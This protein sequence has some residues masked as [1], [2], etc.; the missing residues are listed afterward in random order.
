MSHKSVLQ[1][2]HLDIC[3][4]S[5]VLAFGFV[6]SILFHFSFGRVWIIC[7]FIPFFT[8]VST[9]K[10]EFRL[11]KSRKCTLFWR[12]R[13]LQVYFLC[14]CGHVR[15]NASSKFPR[16]FHRN[17]CSRKQREFRNPCAPLHVFDITYTNGE[18]LFMVW[19]CSLNSKIH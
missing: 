3:S 17:C 14:T 18:H 8:R 12:A 5:N 2:C 9:C 4:F 16:L 15:A 10:V 11:G 7:A 19:L 1:E 6:G 13:V